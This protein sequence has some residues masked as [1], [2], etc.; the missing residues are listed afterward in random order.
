MNCK[1]TER[2]MKA[3]L[4]CFVF[5][6]VLFL[7]E[8][9]SQNYIPYHQKV[10]SAED[11]ITMENYDFALNMYCDAFS[12]VNH[13]FAKDLYNAAICAAITAD[14][15]KMFSLIE[16][17]LK[18][19]VDFDIFETNTAVFATY[20]SDKQWERLKSNTENYKINYLN[21]INTR[22]KDMLDSLNKIDQAV[23]S[24]N[25]YYFLH[26]PKSKKAEIQREKIRYVDSTNCEFIKQLIIKYGYPSERNMGIGN[27]M[28]YYGH[29]CLWHITDS[30]FLEMQKNAFLNGEI[31]VERYVAKMEYCHKDCYNY[32]WKEKS[33]DENCD[34]KRAQIGFPQSHF[35]EHLQ[36]YYKKTN[37]IYGF[38]F[39]YAVSITKK[40][41]D[42]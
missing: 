41:P 9:L 20:F 33:A 40:Q 14:T 15:A 17:C 31:P 6:C 1:Q 22:Y 35:F 42:K 25:E 19:G 21:Q 32:F 37:N 11:A 2:I 10:V 23:R 8:M 36:N 26:R 38:L 5:L 27:T 13:S 7:P 39:L 12:S 18:Q 29:V 28:C 4:F 24:Q 34:K 3:K 16:H 30:S